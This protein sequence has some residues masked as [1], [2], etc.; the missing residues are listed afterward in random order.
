MNS[1]HSNNSRIYGQ[2]NVE[3]KK[4]KIIGYSVKSRDVM[5]YDNGRY[6]EMLKIK[7]NKQPN[8]PSLSGQKCHWSI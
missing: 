4:Y 2:V 5:G 3:Y 8:V 6:I 7:C 1:E